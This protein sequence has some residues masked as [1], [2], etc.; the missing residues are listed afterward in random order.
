MKVKIIFGSALTS[1]VFFICALSLAIIIGRINFANAATFLVDDFNDNDPFHNSLGNIVEVTPAKY[2]TPLEI[3]VDD[4]AFGAAKA[5]QNKLGCYAGAGEGASAGFSAGTLKVIY[6][7]TSWSYYGT[8]L[9][10]NWGNPSTNMDISA[11]DVLYFKIKL[12]NLNS[13]LKI[14]LQDQ[15]ASYFVMLSQYGLLT[16]TNWQDIYIPIGA[17]TG[18]IDL[19]SM[20]AISFLAEHGASSYTQD[21]FL[22]DIKIL[23]KDKKLHDF[24]LFDISRNKALLIEYDVAIQNT[25]FKSNL[26]AGGISADNKYLA[27]RVKGTSGADFYIRLD[28]GRATPLKVLSSDPD[29]DIQVKDNRWQLAYVDLSIPA[30]SG[31]N[32]G[33]LKSVEF[34]FDNT[35]S[36]SSGTLY[37]DNIQFYAGFQ[38]KPGSATYVFGKPQST[39][40]VRIACDDSGNPKLQ[41]KNA[42]EEYIDMRVKGLGYQAT[43]I[44]YTVPFFEEYKLDWTLPWDASRT[45]R[46]Y[47]RSICNRDFPII[48]NMG[49]N[50][51]R[52]WGDPTSEF[53]ARAAAHGLKVIVTGDMRINRESGEN[54]SQTAVRN[55][56]KNNFQ[57][58]INKY[59][60]G[61]TNPSPA[62]LAWALGNEE[63]LEVPTRTEMKD[64]YSLMREMAQIAYEAEIA[65]SLSGEYPYHPVMPVNGDLLF[66]GLPKPNDYMTDDLN[67]D[68]IDL[69]G[70]NLY[71]KDFTNHMWF[72]E[73]N[74]NLFQ[75]YDEKTSKPLII[76]EFGVDAIKSTDGNGSSATKGYEN[77]P[78]QAEWVRDNYEQIMGYGDIV[79]TGCAFEYQDEWWKYAGGSLSAHDKNGSYWGMEK[80]PDGYANEEFFGITQKAPDGSWDKAD[81][82]EDIKER[83]IFNVLLE[84]YRGNEAIW[85]E[86]YSINDH[87][88]GVVNDGY[89]NPNETVFI[90]I[91][92]KN[93][94]LNDLDVKAKLKYFNIDPNYV[95]PYVS[96]QAHDTVVPGEIDFGVVPGGAV[97]ERMFKVASNFASYPITPINYRVEFLAEVTSTDLYDPGITE[98][99]QFRMPVSIVPTILSSTS[100]CALG[101]APINSAKMCYDEH[102]YV[103]ITWEKTST[104]VKGIYFASSADFGRSWTV[105]RKINADTGYDAE[106][107]EIACDNSGQVYIIWED[108]RSGGKR[109]YLDR[110]I[111]H[112]DT[113]LANDIRIDS[114][115]SLSIAENP[116]VFSTENGYIYAVWQE[117]RTAAGKPDIYFNYSTNYGYTWQ[118]QDVMI[119]DGPGVNSSAKPKITAN[120]NGSIFVVWTE[121]NSSISS[122]YITSS[123]DFGATWSSVDQVD[124]FFGASTRPQDISCG[125]EGRVFVVFGDNSKNAYFGIGVIQDNAGISW[126]DYSGDRYCQVNASG[127]L[128]TRALEDM[129][130]SNDNSGKVYITW[131]GRPSGATLSNVYCARSMDSGISW[132][133]I[134]QLSSTPAAGTY[135]VQPMI[136]SDAHGGVYVTWLSNRGGG[137]ATIGGDGQTLIGIGWDIYYDFSMDFGANWNASS[138]GPSD[139][140]VLYYD[141]EDDFINHGYVE[142][143]SGNGNN[144]T[145]VYPAGLA[146]AQRPHASSGIKGNGI[147]F[148]GRTDTFLRKDGA[149]VNPTAGLNAMTVSV[150][151]KTPKCSKN[152]KL[153]SAAWWGGGPHASGWNFGTHYP[154]LWADGD[155]G[156]L[157]AEPTWYDVTRFF[158]DGAWNHAVLTWERNGQIREYIN[159]RLVYAWDVSQPPKNL[160][161]GARLI[162]GGWD[163][164]IPGNPN[165]TTADFPMPGTM[166]EMRIYNRAL[167][168]EE[169]FQLY[170]GFADDFRL[171]RK[172]SPN[173][174]NSF[175]SSVVADQAGKVSLA[176]LDDR[177]AAASNDIYFRLLTFGPRLDPIPDYPIIGG[178]TLTFQ[179][180]ATSPQK[181]P[182]IL[183]ISLEGL[184]PSQRSIIAGATFTQEF[185]P[186]TGVTTGN[187]EWT[188][189]PDVGADFPL[190]F[191][192]SDA[193]YARTA[194]QTMTVQVAEH[195]MLI[196]DYNDANSALNFQHY[197]SIANTRVLR[198]GE[199]NNPTSDGSKVLMIKFSNADG[200]EDWYKSM[201]WDGSDN[202]TRKDITEYNGIRFLVRGIQGGGDV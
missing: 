42:S 45:Y 178:Q 125:R 94:S 182:L 145:V 18:N 198:F 53:M 3:Y 149:P 174:S 86:E 34:I 77:E 111:D 73:E 30:F 55:R 154:E 124:L 144:I 15:T 10:S 197:P 126:Q 177:T 137:T 39:G 175:L 16:T 158:I 69:W 20:K 99:G 81:G 21:I 171:T 121:D 184:D 56:I 1:K 60:A 65:G 127:S 118:Y 140:L 103:Y 57:S 108:R 150:W 161:S 26:S 59:K 147:L 87:E 67:M 62:L 183:S 52:T 27:F 7:T 123:D 164:R 4:F 172:S 113:W 41:V 196:D 25:V 70:S 54:F 13:D 142:D 109:I 46:T 136:V 40:D 6:K 89:F 202:S 128:L 32:K 84:A 201:L 24:D 195:A 98:T 38:D 80:Q 66:I 74:M 189:P 112:G 100:E 29:V 97:I 166:D 131:S 160:G 106:N 85:L 148:S 191:T 104:G 129:R 47:I 116:K 75:V 157:R 141:F 82:L 83:Q 115:P 68:Y 105:S 185:D 36:V 179:V 192:A 190:R 173:L 193:T 92:I 156:T 170:Q 167:P 49:C 96:I 48:K 117:D 107:P 44:G 61:G 181:M 8:N 79:I 200:E 14:L 9:C 186:D 35:I 5:N 71:A 122:T 93:R 180:N 95:D 33:T 88:T 119:G 64:L 146:E 188:P 19:K 22:D 162:V 102:G 194:S 152:I 76:T 169:I 31:L 90:K 187:F 134:Q 63:N 143:K 176:W 165:T 132:E 163:W 199:T 101:A 91:K 120:D 2:I 17:F 37:F 11:R 28:D 43:P 168:I 50:T 78:M 51:L 159:A 58:L 139:G 114:S 72:G 151:F 133:T 135:N 138:E 12:E 110:S 23:A 130:I 153:V 155:A